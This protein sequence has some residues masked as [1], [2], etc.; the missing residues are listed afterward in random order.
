MEKNDN[1]LLPD[2]LGE[3]IKEKS[4]LKSY[5]LGEIIF[6]AGD[7]SEYVYLIK[8]GRVRIC[9]FAKNGTSITLLFHEKGELIGIGGAIDKRER[10]VYCIAAMEG[11]KLWQIKSTD[12]IKL[13]ETKPKLAYQVVLS[14]SRRQRT[15]DTQ[16]LRQVSIRANDRLAVVL[17][18]MA[19]KTPTK[20]DQD[21]KVKIT[22]QEL[23]DMLGTCR[24]TTTSMIS[25]M[26]DEGILDTQ[27]GYIIVKDLKALQ[28]KALQIDS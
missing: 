4:V 10:A 13:M 14:L 28:R 25:I 11:C 16:I 20:P 17:F 7:P 1:G 21:I 6:G 18:D 12:F 23:S 2:D 5:S 26:K 27:K 9:H 22:Q 19:M 3:L 24:Q 8:E 15:L